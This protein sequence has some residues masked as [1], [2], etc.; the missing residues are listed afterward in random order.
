MLKRV[1]ISL[2]LFPFTLLPFYFSPSTFISLVSPA[3]VHATNWNR[4]NVVFN[5]GIR[6]LN[7]GNYQKALEFF[8]KAIDIYK[9]DPAAFYNRGIAN[10]E[11]ENYKEA[12]ED[13]KKSLTMDGLMYTANTHNNIGFSYL[14]LED[15][16][17]ALKHLN[18]AISIKSDDG[19]YYKNRGNVYLNQEKWEKALKDY[20]TAKGKYLKSKEN[21]DEYFY[22]DIGYIH[23]NLGSYQ[24]AIDNYDKAIEINPNESMF[25]SEKGDALYELGE[26]DIACENYIKASKL[27]DEETKNYLNSRDGKWCK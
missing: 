27:G 21:I 11:L 8:S 7:Q 4:Y 25:Y 1:R 2:S 17:N 13:Y 18:K 3:P 23:F 14:Q 6:N 19:S 5:S 12:I 10:E 20:E 26:E 9:R 24:Q 15:F 16:D 22:N